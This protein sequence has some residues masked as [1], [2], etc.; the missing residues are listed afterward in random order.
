VV[1]DCAVP[2]ENGADADGADGHSFGTL[3][4]L[5]LL[6]AQRTASGLTTRSPSAS[7]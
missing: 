3:D 2:V 6:A 5:V 1:G 7:S 4:V